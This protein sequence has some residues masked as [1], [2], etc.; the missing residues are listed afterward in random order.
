MRS[1]LV[2]YSLLACH[3]HCFRTHLQVYS[4][5]L[6][7]LFSQIHGVFSGISRDNSPNSYPSIRCIRVEVNNKDWVTKTVNYSSI[8]IVEYSGT[9]NHQMKIQILKIFLLHRLRTSP[10]LCRIKHAPS[11]RLSPIG[12]YSYSTIATWI[13]ENNCNCY[14]I[15]GLR[16]QLP[17][18]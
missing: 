2:L 13:Q 8:K 10:H 6:R 15:L 9:S 17:M 18:R 1:R 3:H 16:S 7:M 12:A 4:T 5:T 14:V 11:D